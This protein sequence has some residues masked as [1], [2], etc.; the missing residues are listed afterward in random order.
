ECTGLAVDDDDDIVSLVSNYL[1]RNGFTVLFARSAAEAIAIAEAH[2]GRID[3]LL[4][5]VLMTGMTG[6]ELATYMRKRRGGIRVIYISGYL[7]PEI[8]GDLATTGSIILSKPFS[9]ADLAQNIR[10]MVRRDD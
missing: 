1:A 4:T 8:Q 6:P 3:L 10:A 9:L 7:P 5:D 2:L